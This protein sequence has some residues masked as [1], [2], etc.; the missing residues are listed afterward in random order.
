METKA[1]D[2]AEEA[3][4]FSERMKAEG[5]WDA[6]LRRRDELV[7]LGIRRNRAH[8]KVVEEFSRAAG[9]TGPV[10][11]YRDGYKTVRE[12]IREFNDRKRAREAE[13]IA[14]GVPVDVLYPKGKGGKPAAV[15]S[16]GAASV[17]TA[18]AAMGS[19]GGLLLDQFKGRQSGAFEVIQFVFDHIDV[20]DVTPE[21]APSPG[22]WSLLM[23][24]R[25]SEFLAQEFY[26]SIYPRLI[27][28]RGQLELAEAKND[29]GREIGD[30][31][32]RVE[33]ARL[34][35]IGAGAGTCA[36]AGGGPSGPVVAIEPGGVRE[37]ESGG[38]VDG[39]G[40]GEDVPDGGGACA[41][42]EADGG[43]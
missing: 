43:A 22:A 25:G 13:A 33:R 15:S 28:S 11:E 12:K 8:A 4:E 18:A 7:G 1:A 14:K 37:A 20:G 5:R 39:A 9:G 29:D 2:R 23:R 21:M 40:L 27:P 3:I 10:K 19:K 34:I 36:E 38:G 17:P 35:A 24:V 16:A 31:I 26:K 6:F 41:D 32:G 42:P 30:L